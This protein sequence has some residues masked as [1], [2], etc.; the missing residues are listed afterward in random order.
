MGTGTGAGTETRTVAEMGTRTDSDR[1]EER[2]RSARSRSRIVNAIE[3]F[4]SARV[5]ISAD[6]GWRLRAP[7]SSVRKGREGTNGGGGER[8]SARWDGSGE[9][10]REANEAQEAAQ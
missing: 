5:I 2:R 7:D 10:G 8:K 4:Y 3:R 6:R 9:G 1:V